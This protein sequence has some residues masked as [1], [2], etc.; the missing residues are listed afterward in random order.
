MNSHILPDLVKTINRYKGEHR[1]EMP[2]YALVSSS[3]VDKLIDE[4]RKAG[5]YDAVLWLQ[6]IKV[7]KSL[8]TTR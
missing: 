3:Q 7:A 4:I 8:V 6:T 5:G 1:G 2:L